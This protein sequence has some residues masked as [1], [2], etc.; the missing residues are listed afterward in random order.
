MKLSRL[1]TKAPATTFVFGVDLLDSFIF[2]Q[3]APDEVCQ[4]VSVG[5]Q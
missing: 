1:S 4:R 3:N 2:F 5:L